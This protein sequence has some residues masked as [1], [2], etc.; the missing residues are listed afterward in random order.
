MIIYC[1]VILNTLVYDVCPKCL[2]SIVKF[3]FP[4][5]CS[6]LSHGSIDPVGVLSTVSVFVVINQPK[7]ISKLFCV[8]L[9]IQCISVCTQNCQLRS[10]S[11]CI[12]LWSKVLIKPSRLKFLVFINRFLLIF[13][14][15]VCLILDI[16]HLIYKY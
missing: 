16:C 7:S 9:R 5:L 2:E 13:Q 8:Q 10:V 4:E 14:L 12:L 6:I 1:L 15:L 3:I 11:S